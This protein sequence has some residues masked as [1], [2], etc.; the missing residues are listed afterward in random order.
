MKVFMHTNI[1]LKAAAGLILIVIGAGLF[2]IFTSAINEAESMGSSMD[3]VPFAV[4]TYWPVI[5][6]LDVIF[7]SLVLGGVKLA[8]FGWRIFGLIIIVA[9]IGVLTLGIWHHVTGPPMDYDSTRGEL[10]KIPVSSELNVIV[11]LW[12]GLTI[13]GGLWLTAF[14]AERR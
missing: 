1:S 12:A 4:F 6:V 8:G 11:Y 7:L 10:N 13:L 2:V 9:G 5:L 3:F 14:P